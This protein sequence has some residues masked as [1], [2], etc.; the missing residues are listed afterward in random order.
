MNGHPILW[1]CAR[2]EGHPGQ[3]QLLKKQCKS[4]SDWPK[5]L[6]LAEQHGLSPLLQKHLKEAQITL[7]P[8]MARTLHLLVRRQQK[9]AETRLKILEEILT[10]FHEE[11]IQPILLKGAALS[12]TLYP[13]P[14]LRPMRDLDIL[15]APQEVNRAQQLLKANGYSQARAPI[16]ADHHHLPSLHKKHDEM[17]ICVELHRALYPQCPPYYPPF[18]FDDLKRSAQKIQMGKIE[19]LVFSHL[20]MIYYLYQHGLRAP[21]T[22][23]CYK[24][25]N[26]ADLTGYIEKHYGEIDWQVLAHKFPALMRAL[27]LLHQIA[28]FD[29]AIIAKDFVPGRVR[30]RLLPPKPYRGWPQRRRKTIKTGQTTLLEMVK[31]TL[32]PPRWWIKIYYATGPS[33]LR[34]ARAILFDHPKT[35]WW[36]ARLLYQ[37]DRSQ[38]K[39]TS[40]P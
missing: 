36:W 15:V 34:F 1:L 5:I 19:A 31:E 39:G 35:L 6:E 16:P 11:E 33:R 8:A 29:F 14:A 2:I 22:Y 10:I 28:P 21:L 12:L 38:G 4:C 20:E 27:P 17:E 24:L 7:P 13:D 18:D 32:C 37:L 25:I 40:L 9:Q 26:V 30:Q 23:E 3:R